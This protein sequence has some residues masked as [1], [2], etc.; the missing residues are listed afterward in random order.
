MRITYVTTYD[1]QDVHNWSGIGYYMGKALEGQ[2][3]DL[4]YV[5]KL[6]SK[7]SLSQKIKKQLYARL[8]GET[9]MVDRS[10]EIAKHYAWQISQRLKDIKTDIIFSPSSIPISMLDDKRPIVFWT[11]AT[12]NGMINFYPGYSN[13]TSEI[14]KNGAALEQAALSNCSLAIYSSDWAAKTAI[15][16]YDVD[17]SKVKVV[18]FGANLDGERTLDMV[19]SSL[20]LKSTSICKLLFLGVEWDR[21]GGE[22]AVAVTNIL[23]KM[24]L[25]TELFV[26][27]C[28]P[29]LEE[30]VSKNIRKLGYIS[31]STSSG[32]KVIHDLLATSHF[33]ILPTKAD[34]APMVFAEASSMGLPVITSNVGG[35][36]TQIKDGL[37]GKKFEL[38]DSPNTYAKYIASVFTDTKRYEEL[39]LSS[40]NEYINRLNWKVAA[41]EVKSMLTKFC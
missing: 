29:Q 22:T 10:K 37:N 13:L 16:N 39:S 3:I 27:G 24:G 32:M 23:N 14:M 11:D 33:L 21:K 5:G 38:N 28:T 12:F 41:K 1:A 6:N 15:E 9:Y 34:C 30:S 17:P 18:P 20:K 26:A 31:K 8:L 25:P 19:K 7:Y 35:I 4:N 40:Y 36:S 2:S